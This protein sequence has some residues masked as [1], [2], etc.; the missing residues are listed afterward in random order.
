MQTCATIVLL[1]WPPLAATA[2]AANLQFP[3]NYLRDSEPRIAGDG[4]LVLGGL[5]PGLTGMG[6]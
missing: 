4:N 6:I 3:C 1:D 2:R 5:P